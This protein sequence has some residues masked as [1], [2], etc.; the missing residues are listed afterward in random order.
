MLPVSNPDAFAL[1]V[2][3][4]VLG[5][6]LLLSLLVALAY[7]EN[8]L[9]SLA[10]YLTLMM[11]F[12]LAGSL[13]PTRQ[14]LIQRLL[15]VMGPSL[16]AGLQFWLLR[17]R[18][19][20]RVGLTAMVAW[21]GVT[22]GLLG[23]HVAG[24]NTALNASLCVLWVVL[25][26]MSALYLSVQAWDTAGPWKWWLLL[27]HGLGALVAASFLTDLA[28]AKWA[29]WPVLFMLLLQAPPI[30]VSLVWR[31]R[32]LNEI[33]LRSATA[34]TVD[35]LTGLAT[36]PVLL[37]RL[38]RIMSR[39]QQP[40]HS[41]VNSALFLI[42][43]KNWKGLLHELGPEFNEKLLLEAALRLRRSIGD[44]DL[45][46]RIHGGRFAVLAQGLVNP[47]EVTTLATRLVVSGLR[48]D[49]P[50]LPGVEFKFNV[51]VTDL[52][53]FKPLALP[54]VQIWLDTLANRFTAWPSSHRSRSIL[55]VDN[56][57]DQTDFSGADAS[58]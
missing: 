7:H 26:V 13:L 19:I 37:E 1:G 18:K 4:G 52:K 58:D 39:N 50:L 12:A 57:P 10:G 31:S 24:G 40:R 38:M 15:L 42:E 49:S 45:A 48:I 8:T 34:N 6:V 3:A 2:A 11:A 51:I 20:S 14:E 43:V 9:L 5:L 33:K 22:L 16:M 25:L 29:Y 30:Y 56:G 41:S 47:Q 21:A 35:P 55:V 54:A 27:G 17:N 36:T 46:A 28:D 32:L 44:N 23:F 53:R